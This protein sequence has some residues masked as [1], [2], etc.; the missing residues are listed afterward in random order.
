MWGCCPASD[1]PEHRVVLRPA[2][3]ASCQASELPKALPPISARL[4]HSSFGIRE[5]LSSI[6]PGAAPAGELP[7]TAAM[8]DGGAGA[9]LD[10]LIA[11]LDAQIKAGKYKKALKLADDGEVWAGLGRMDGAGVPR[12][13]GGVGVW[14][15]CL[16]PCAV[17]AWGFPLGA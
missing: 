5:R 2:I 13:G 10:T 14:E 6:H 12:V 16:G 9:Q 8:T 11:R 17:A 1:R 4:V 15:G 3:N 7:A